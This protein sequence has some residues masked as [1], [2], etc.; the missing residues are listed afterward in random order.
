MRHY[1]YWDFIGMLTIKLRTWLLTTVVVVTAQS[2]P[3]MH[4]RRDVV[5]LARRFEKLMPLSL[6]L[7][8]GERM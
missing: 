4:K 1:I 3:Q 8:D 7:L 2:L 5:I 6:G